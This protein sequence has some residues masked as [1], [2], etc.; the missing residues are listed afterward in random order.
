MDADMDDKICMSE[1]KSYIRKY[2]LAIDE[3]IAEQMYAEAASK[4]GVTHD[5]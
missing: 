2:E 5:H 4:R 3:N 1:L